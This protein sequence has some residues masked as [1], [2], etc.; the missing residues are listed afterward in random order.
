MSVLVELN[1]VDFG[2]HGLDFRHSDWHRGQIF[3]P[4]TRLPE[5]NTMMG[6]CELGGASAGRV[7]RIIL[8]HRVRPA[9]REAESESI[10]PRPRPMSTAKPNDVNRHYKSPMQGL[11]VT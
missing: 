1:D 10:H 7:Q 2:S 4:Q 5:Q 11:L 8:K 6:G 3:G 9:T